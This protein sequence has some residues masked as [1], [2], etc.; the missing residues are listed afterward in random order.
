VR[1]V[2]ERY[3]GIELP[4][5]ELTAPSFHASVRWNA[6]QVAS[7]VRTWSAVPVFIEAT[8]RDP[9]P[10][11]EAEV[12][13]AFGGPDLARDLSFPLYLRAARL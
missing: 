3:T 13:A 9:V 6:R 5:E 8:N 10:E 7:F 11:L 12:E 1:L 4:G 2:D